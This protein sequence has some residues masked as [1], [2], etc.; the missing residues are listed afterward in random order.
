MKLNLNLRH[1]L[2]KSLSSRSAQLTVNLRALVCL[3]APVLFPG[4]TIA[5]NLFTDIHKHQHIMQKLR[6]FISAVLVLLTVILPS[7]LAHA[8]LGGSLVNVSAYYP[9]AGSLFADGGNQTVSGEIEYPTGTFQNYS[10]SWQIDITDTQL[11]ITDTTSNG[12]PYF[13][14]SF[15]GWILTIVSGPSILSAAVNDTSD[16]DPVGISVVGGNQLL[17]NYSGVD[18]PTGGTSI[19]D[20]TVVPEPAPATLIMAT[21][22]LFRLRKWP[23]QRV[24]RISVIES[25]SRFS[26]NAL[27]HCSVSMNHRSS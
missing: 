17:L 19:I 7:G 15:N 27:F 5:D 13:P 14:A 9:D 8:G 12:F 20:I 24:R 1:A 10:G 2:M 18:G 21:G 23:R 6:Q 16:F 11:T 4:Q 25:V 3:L 26:Q 22:L